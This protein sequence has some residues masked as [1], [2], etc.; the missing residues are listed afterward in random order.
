MS[1]PATDVVNERLLGKPGHDGLL[2]L[3]PLHDDILTACRA[4][5]HPRKNLSVDERMVPTKARI[6]MKQY[7]KDKPTKWGYKL[8]VMA[9]SKSGYT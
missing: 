2:R 4:H 6:G 8:F 1:D 7:M 5:Y 9:D 3:K